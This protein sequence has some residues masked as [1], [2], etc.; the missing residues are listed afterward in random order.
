MSP[1]SNDSIRINCPV[2]GA[3]VEIRKAIGVFGRS[4]FWAGQSTSQ[5]AVILEFLLKL[6]KRSA[7]PLFHG[8]FEE[9]YAP[10]NT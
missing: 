7:D 4:I 10:G 5:F 1:S 6:R 9:M 2:D 3:R 8:I